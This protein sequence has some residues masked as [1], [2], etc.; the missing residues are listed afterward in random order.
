[1]TCRPIRLPSAS[2]SPSPEPESAEAVIAALTAGF[3]TLSP[4]LARAARYL[5]DHAREIGVTSMRGMATAAEVHPN[6]LVRLAQTLGFDGYESLRARFRDFVVGE[7]IGGFR[8]RATALR[9]LAARGGTGEVVAEMAAALTQNTARLWEP[10]NVAALEQA[11]EAILR[12]RRVYVLGMGSALSLAQQFWY[13]ARQAF[14]H[15]SAIP[16]PGSVPIDDL[17]EIGGE[18]VLMALTFQPYR[19]ETVAAVRHARDRRPHVIAI[20]DSPTSPLAALADTVLLA[21]THSPQFF[22]SHA[23]ATALLEVLLAVLVARSGE[24][25]ADRIA[26]FHRDRLAAGLYEEPAALASR[27][28]GETR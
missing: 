22:Q 3:A 16:R 20:T 9:D 19:A 25:S 2:L 4:Q 14:G 28:L 18:D 11:A 8:A 24:D 21:R 10:P 17:A 26:R 7:G 6:T 5:V 15:V 27:G 12:A 1:M 23:A 13:V